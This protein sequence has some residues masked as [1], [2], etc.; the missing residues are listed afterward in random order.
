M[1]LPASKKTIINEGSFNNGQMSCGGDGQMVPVPGSH[2]GSPGSNPGRGRFTVATNFPI[3]CL[4]VLN[5]HIDGVPILR[6]N[7][8]GYPFGRVGEGG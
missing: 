2:M 7:S 3:F 4:L 1:Q 6:T 8:A 5:V